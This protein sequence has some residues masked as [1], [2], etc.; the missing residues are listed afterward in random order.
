MGE[1]SNKPKN[2]TYG[3]AFI[4]KGVKKKKKPVCTKN[5]SMIG[6]F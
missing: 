5:E 4:V 2:V 1:F 3:L 6:K